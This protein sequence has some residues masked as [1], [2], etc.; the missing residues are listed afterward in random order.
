M[1]QT[2]HRILNYPRKIIEIYHMPEIQ[3]RNRT[4]P[5]GTKETAHKT[6]R[7]TPWYF[8]TSTLP[9]WICSFQNQHT[10]IKNI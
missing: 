2:M 5:E 10:I 8:F 7:L 3:L 1:A 9:W 4:L 6:L